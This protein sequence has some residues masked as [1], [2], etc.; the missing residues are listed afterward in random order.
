MLQNASPEHNFGC[1]LYDAPVQAA[2]AHH[3]LGSVFLLGTQKP[4]TDC[5]NPL[6]PHVTCGGP[7]APGA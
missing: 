3:K 4:P 2:A 6:M 7:A 5:H 1:L